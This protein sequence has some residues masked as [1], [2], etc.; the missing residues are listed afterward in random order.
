MVFAESISTQAI[1]EGQQKVKHIGSLFLVQQSQGR[2]PLGVRGNG[3]HVIPSLAD[4]A[5]RK[6]RT[7]AATGAI[8]ASGARPQ[9]LL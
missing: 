4:T 2:S 1:G 6:L 5:P 9:R 3:L 8:F 7:F